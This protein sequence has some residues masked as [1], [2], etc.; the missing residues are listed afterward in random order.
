M[1]LGRITQSAPAKTLNDEDLDLVRRA[2][3][4]DASAFAELVTEHRARI[5]VQIFNMVQDE[6]EASEIF[7]RTSVK[8][9]QAISKFQGRSSFYTWLYKI[10]KYETINW[11]R[12]SRPA[13]VELDVNI[14]CTAAG[15]DRAIQ[16]RE[17]RDLVLDAIE[18]LPPKQRAVIK[19]KDLEGFQYSEIARILKCSTGTVMSRLF[20]ARRKLQ[21]RLRPF[22]E[23]LY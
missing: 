2:Q 6:E 22:Y 23:S 11:L 16:K 10:A 5:V 3:N 9:W 14:R 20:H 8:V 12:S 17:I 19:L 18:H 1:F 4:G 15:P 7:Q 13:F 21:I